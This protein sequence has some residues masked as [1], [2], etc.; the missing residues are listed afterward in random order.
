MSTL[1]SFF[2]RSITTPDADATATTLACYGTAL[3][4]L[5]CGFTA[6]GLLGQEIADMFLTILAVLTVSLLFVLLG[7]LTE[8]HQRLKK[9]EAKQP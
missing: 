2:T 1:R 7:E 5:V 8:I 3:L 6:V 9:I 4:V